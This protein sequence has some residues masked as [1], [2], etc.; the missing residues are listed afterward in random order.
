MTIIFKKHALCVRG[1]LPVTI[2][3]GQWSKFQTIRIAI[4]ITQELSRETMHYAFVK[5]IKDSQFSKRKV[6]PL[7]FSSLKKKNTETSIAVNQE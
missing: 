2:S 3:R 4:N 1:F 6:M 7:M 5:A